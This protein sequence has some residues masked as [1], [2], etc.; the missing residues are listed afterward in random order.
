MSQK[1]VDGI[2]EQVGVRAGRN[3][4]VRCVICHT[5]MHG[6]ALAKASHAKKHVRTGDAVAREIYNHDGPKTV[7]ERLP[8]STAP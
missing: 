4:R 2:F 1:D 7:Y 3:K 8:Q 5:E 6:H